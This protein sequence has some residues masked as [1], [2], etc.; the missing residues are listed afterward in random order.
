VKLNNTPFKQ[1]IYEIRSYKGKQK[2]EVKENKY[3][4]YQNL[5]DIVKAVWGVGRCFIYNT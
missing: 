3:T 4:T 5:W 2:I 1:P